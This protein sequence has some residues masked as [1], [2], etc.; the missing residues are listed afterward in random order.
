[1][2]KNVETQTLVW[3]IIITLFWGSVIGYSVAQP[4]KH[5]VKSGA[6]NKVI[7]QDPTLVDDA[8]QLGLS[9]YQWVNLSFT[10]NKTAKDGDLPDGTPINGVFYGPNTISIS[11]G[12]NKQDELVSVAYEIMH[13]YWSNL[14]DD[15]K[16]S[17]EQVM[18]NFYDS[19]PKFQDITRDFIGDASLLGDERSATACTKVPTY[20]LTDDFNTYCNQF[21]PNRS[22]LF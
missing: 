13:Y 14:P 5:Y 22:I 10:D 7:A 18:Q 9:D 12:L 3:S 20:I 19:D 15:N 6:A 21:I 1:M 4:H 17:A 11:T 8:K 2:K 16:Q